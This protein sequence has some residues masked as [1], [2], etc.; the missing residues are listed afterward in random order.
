M[1]ELYYVRNL[2]EHLDNK[3]VRLR[4]QNIVTAFKKAMNN[5]AKGSEESNIL[6]EVQVDPTDNYSVKACLIVFDLSLKAL[7][8]CEDADSRC[9]MIAKA[10]EREC[11]KLQTLPRG[12]T[13]IQQCPDRLEK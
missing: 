4:L 3:G 1:G 5:K 11:Q 13:S 2:L 12:C 10:Y 6:K 9:D 7:R 8:Q